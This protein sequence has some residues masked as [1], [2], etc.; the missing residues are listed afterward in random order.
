MNPE[1]CLNC[2]GL[3]PGEVIFYDKDS[4]PPELPKVCKCPTEK[5]TEWNCGCTCGGCACHDNRME[6]RNRAEKDE[7]FGP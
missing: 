6:E 4:P 1:L 5:C 7:C 2:G 3:K